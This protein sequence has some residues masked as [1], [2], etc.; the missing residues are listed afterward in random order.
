MDDFCQRSGNN[1][2][3]DKIGGV[4]AEHAKAGMLD[5]A[6][7]KLQRAR[8]DQQL[9]GIEPQALRGIIGAMG[10]VAVR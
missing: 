9:G 2:A 10:S 5:E 7:I 1:G 4:L 3:R 6:A 8:I